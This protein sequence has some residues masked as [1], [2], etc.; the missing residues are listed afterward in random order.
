MLRKYFGAPVALVTGGGRRLGR[1]IV[2]AL[3]REGFDVIINYNESK[4]DAEKTYQQV[5]S[6]GR[7]ALKIQA[8]VS[9]QLAVRRMVQASIQKFRRIDVLVNNA[10]IFIDSTFMGTTE[11]TW[12]NTLGTNLK[13]VF[14]C[15][16]AVAKHMLL[17]KRGRIINVASLGGLQSWSKHLPYSV[18]KAGVIMLTRC[19]AK[20]LAPRIT[21][22][23]IA[24]GTVIIPDEKSTSEDHISRKK[25]LLARYG[26]PSDITDLIIFLSTKATYMTGQTIVIDGGR[27]V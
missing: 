27:F 2:L 1:Q 21:V 9:D 3:A 4:R 13:G 15:S 10:A 16:Q 6:M 11:E 26:K 19:M 7:K 17:K 5:L 23:A 12:S 24:P 25:I 8:D 20:E 22:N 14:L 18:A